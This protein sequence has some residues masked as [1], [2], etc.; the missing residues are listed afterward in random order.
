MQTSRSTAI[1]V[2]L[3]CCVS[4]AACSTQAASEH[5]LESDVG[6]IAQH[7]EVE[8]ARTPGEQDSLLK[9]TF[10]VAESLRRTR[11]AVIDRMGRPRRILRNPIE[12]T[13]VIGQTDTI[14]SLRYETL[15]AAFWVQGAEASGELLIDLA[16]RPPWPL[17][18]DVPSSAGREDLVR[19]WSEPELV[20]TSADTVILNWNVWDDDA[21]EYLQAYLVQNEIRKLRWSLY[22]D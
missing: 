6:V 10:A 7:T 12:S 2:V 15:S 21:E 18:V 16:I 11:S 9:S 17:D 1:H 4:S 5:A 19:L 14:V 8:A 3:L 20:R 13:H 22:V